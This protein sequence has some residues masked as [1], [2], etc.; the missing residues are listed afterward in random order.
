MLTKEN[1]GKFHL[2]LGLDRKILHNTG[3][4]VSCCHS[5]QELGANFIFHIGSVS[6]C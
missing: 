1:V 6:S 3:H 4:K 2:R 5:N